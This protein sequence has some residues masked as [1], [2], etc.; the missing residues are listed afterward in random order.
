MAQA[1]IYTI[2]HGNKLFDD[3]VGMLKTYRIRTLVDIRSYPAS[4][5]EAFYCWVTRN[6]SS[7]VVVPSK[8]F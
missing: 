3:L 6:T 5:R 1:Q 7:M 8:T 4:R 2:G